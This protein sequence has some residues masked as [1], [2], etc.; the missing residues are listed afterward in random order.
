MELQSH[1]LDADGNFPNHPRLP[2]LVYPQAVTLDVN[3]PAS[4]FEQ[5]FEK[6]GWTGSWRNGVYPF[7]HYHSNAHEVLG[8]AVGSVRVQFGGPNGPVVSVAAGDVA[9][10]PAGTAHKRIDA[11]A[12]LLVVGAY[13]RGQED[14]DL[15]REDADTARAKRRVATTALPEA[16]PVLGAEG[17]LLEEW[18]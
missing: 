9:I 13:P 6:H 18:R 16:D 1:L 4:T 8:I 2:L 15:M 5:L 17:P 3:D 14:Y 10:L 11:T 12:D 7:H